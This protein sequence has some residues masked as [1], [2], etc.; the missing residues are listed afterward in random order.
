MHSVFIQL[1]NN[2]KPDSCLLDGELY[3]SMTQR[4]QSVGFIRAC[5]WVYLAGVSP[6]TASLNGIF[7]TPEVLVRN[8]LPGRGRIVWR[9]FFLILMSCISRASSAF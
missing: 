1:E 5:L 6:F 7:D 3:E 4:I 2:N 8:K 9:L